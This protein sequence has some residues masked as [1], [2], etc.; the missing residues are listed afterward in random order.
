MPKIEP[1]IYDSDTQALIEDLV[2]KV[3]EIVEVVNDLWEN[4]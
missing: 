1:V 3:N 2:L 4:D